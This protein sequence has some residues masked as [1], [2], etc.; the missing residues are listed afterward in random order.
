MKVFNIIAS[1]VTFSLQQVKTQ[2][3]NF[4]TLLALTFVTPFF[5]SVLTQ[6]T[7]NKH[8]VLTNGH[9]HKNIENIP[10]ES[11]L[12]SGDGVMK[13]QTTSISKKYEN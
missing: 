5:S 11:S 6:A 1:F 10:V 8:Y 4:L 3:D 9:L 2:C 12:V 7:W 13:Q